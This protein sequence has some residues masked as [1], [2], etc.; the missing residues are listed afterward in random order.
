MAPSLRPL[1]SVLSSMNHHTFYSHNLTSSLCISSV[2]SLLPD[3]VSMLSL[4]FH[5]HYSTNSVIPSGTLVFCNGTVYI[6]TSVLSHL[7]CS[8]FYADSSILMSCCSFFFTLISRVVPP[9][10]SFTT[11][12]IP[13]TSFHFASGLIFCLLGEELGV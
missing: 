3:S 6:C 11:L 9:M 1:L 8:F 5:M 10:S 13:A 4:L 12:N 2:N 7:K